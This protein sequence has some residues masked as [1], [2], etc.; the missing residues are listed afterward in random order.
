MAD[1]LAV[2]HRELDHDAHA[3]ARA[4]AEE[5]ERPPLPHAP[6]AVHGLGLGVA[7]LPATVFDLRRRGVQ[8]DGN[9]D[10]RQWYREHRPHR[11]RPER[12]QGHALSNH[13]AARQRQHP[14]SR[15]VDGVMPQRHASHSAQLAKPH[16]AQ[17]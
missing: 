3:V 4:I 16:F 2:F 5:R 13:G 15:A 17:P 9:A 6:R 11:G 7:N 10:R 8:R 14:G 12:A 1:E